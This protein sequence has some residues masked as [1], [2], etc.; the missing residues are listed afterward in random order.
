[1]LCKRDGTLVRA[2]SGKQLM[3]IPICAARKN[4]MRGVKVG[5]RA[6]MRAGKVSIEHGRKRVPNERPNSGTAAPASGSGL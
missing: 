4:S 1:M 2:I 5:P 6:I 3:Q